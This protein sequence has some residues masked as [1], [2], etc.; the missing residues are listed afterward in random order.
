M[1]VLCH[2]VFNLNLCDLDI[3]FSVQI[4]NNIVFL[5]VHFLQTVN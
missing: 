1:N 3:P 2:N 5:F 4:F